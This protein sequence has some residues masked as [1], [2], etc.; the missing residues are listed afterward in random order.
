MP[1]PPVTAVSIRA[2]RALGRPPTRR[3]VDWAVQELEAGR[4]GPHLRIL[5]GLTEPFD[6]LE[7]IRYVDAA[8]AELKVPLLQKETSIA[9]YAEELVAALAST[10]SLTNEILSDLADL[11]IETEYS[12]LLMSFYLLHSAKQDLQAQG[13]QHYWEGANASNIDEIVIA[14]ARKWLAGRAG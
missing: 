9:T 10:H 13:D 11:C 3:W 2:W 14:E 4:D 8:L 12:D 6:D 7:V 5:A 1:H